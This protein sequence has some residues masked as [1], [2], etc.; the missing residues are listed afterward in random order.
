MTTLLTLLITFAIS[1]ALALALTPLASPPQPPETWIE[2]RQPL[3]PRRSVA[4]LP[5]RLRE[6]GGAPLRRREELTAGGHHTLVVLVP[7]AT[8]VRGPII[9]TVLRITTGPR[10]SASRRRM[11]RLA[12]TEA[13]QAVRASR[14]DKPAGGGG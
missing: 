5:N 11:R 8:E 7:Q 2:E 4:G 6:R 12:D 9:V 13:S 3:I 10:P 14:R 1:L